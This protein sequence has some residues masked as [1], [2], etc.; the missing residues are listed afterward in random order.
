MNNPSPID[1]GK[2]IEVLDILRG[3]A[4]LGIIFHNMLFFSGYI[5]LP[6]DRIKESMNFQLNENIYDIIDVFISGK[7]YTIFSLLFAAGFYIQLSKHREEDSGTFLK[8]YMRRLFILML[9]G[10]IHS[11]IWEGDVLLTYSIIGFILILFRKAKPGFLLFWAIFFMLLPYLT[12]Y[13]IAAFNRPENIPAAGSEI[14]AAHISY[15]DIPSDILINTFREGSLAELFRLNFQ[16]LL[17]K[18]LT[19][20]PSGA[21]FRFLGLFLLGYWLS[22]KG[23]FMRTS[24]SNVLLIVGLAGGL[25]VTVLTKYLWSRFHDLYLIFD[26]LWMAG[27]LMM[28]FGYIAMIYRIA[29]MP[30]GKKLLGGLSKV[31]R[32]ALS[33][34]IS[35][36]VLMILIFYNFGLNLFG[37]SSLMLSSSIALSILIVQIILSNIWLRYYRFGPLEWV[38]RSLTYKKRIRNA[39]KD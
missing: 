35:Q 26:V 37:I 28:A 25:L 39:L 17:H 13:L 4:L 15:S 1:P 31:G 8:T 24:K 30:S 29:G 32:T 18:Y 22:T 5:F 23:F 9:F 2:R 16:I 14:T 3:F 7:F 11:L 21:Y 10:C 36:T 27:Q 19:Y 38:W 12:K 20:F 6:F 33:N 34:Y